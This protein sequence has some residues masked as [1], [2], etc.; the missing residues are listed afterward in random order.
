M[1][2]TNLTEGQDPS[3]DIDISA[4][5]STQADEA[6]AAVEPQDPVLTQT[7]A[8]VQ[9]PVQAA[10]T[11]QIQALI[12]AQVYARAQAQ[13]DSAVGSR[14]PRKVE[15]MIVE[16]VAES[17]LFQAWGEYRVVSKLWKEEVEKVARRKWLPT[18][19]IK[20]R[21]E[22]N[23]LRLKF[24]PDEHDE[25]R[26]R[27]E[28]IP[29]QRDADG[30]QALELAVMW[31]QCFSLSGSPLDDW[32]SL[33]GIGGSIPLDGVEF[34]DKPTEISLLWVP[35]ISKVVACRYPIFNPD[36]AVTSSRHPLGET[37]SSLSYY[38]YGN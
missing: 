22:P 13:A 16:I 29:R 35:L 36:A 25:K 10:A 32:A 9:A 37:A 20:L 11:L 21:E 24:V 18:A 30:I 33:G 19:S 31:R 6:E 28:L 3:D 8:Q 2:S 38:F 4:A 14:F 7:T 12:L 15:A 23:E 27:F 26:A 34:G 1:A 17:S 5:P